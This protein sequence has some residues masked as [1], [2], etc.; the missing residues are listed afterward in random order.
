MALKKREL[1]SVTGF[2]GE[3]SAGSGV[4]SV[5]EIVSIAGIS[6]SVSGLV[7]SLGLSPSKLNTKGESETAAS[8]ALATASES[9]CDDSFISPN[10]LF[11]ASSADTS[12]GASVLSGNSRESPATFLASG[13]PDR[14][15]N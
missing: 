2:V 4:N 15:P 12:L 11:M 14:S 13:W 1:I 8:S 9:L 10:I 6:K 5:V 3:S 7:S